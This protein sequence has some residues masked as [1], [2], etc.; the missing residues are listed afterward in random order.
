MWNVVCKDEHGCEVWET[1]FRTEWEAEDYAMSLMD[2]YPEL[3]FFAE[4]NDVT[5]LYEGT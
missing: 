4:H 3:E 2:S 1:G 5:E